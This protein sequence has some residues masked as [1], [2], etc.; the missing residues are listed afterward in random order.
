MFRM[1][2]STQDSLSCIGNSLLGVNSKAE[3]RGGE[4][5]K[6]LSIP[7]LIIAIAVVFIGQSV[8]VCEAQYTNS[9][10]VSAMKGHRL[11]DSQGNYLGRID[12]LTF[13]GY[14]QPDS[15]ILSVGENKLVALPFSAL[16]PCTWKDPF[17]VNITKE[18]V[19]HAPIYSVNVGTNFLTC[20]GANCPFPG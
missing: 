8:A 13:I 6:N 7:L 10:M 12:G 2:T 5:M 20:C 16:L 18:Q 14:E 3:I 4:T 9:E 15:I 11:Y 1:A 19:R 17:V